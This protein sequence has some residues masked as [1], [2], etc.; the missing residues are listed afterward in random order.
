MDTRVDEI[1]DGIFRCSTLVPDIGPT[2]F[3]FNQFVVRGEHESLLFHTGPRALFASV[4]EAVAT[5]T[6]LDRL[7]WITFGHYEADE[8]GAMND[9]LEAVPNAQVA[10]T[11]IGVLVSINDQAAREPLAMAPDT[12]FDL[13]G[14]RVRGIDTPHVPHGWDAHVLFE[15]TTRTLLCGDLFTHLGDGPALT[16]ND[17][18]DTAAMAEDVFGATALTPTT[19]P[20]IRALADLQPTT[21]AIMHGSSYTG[22]ASGALLALADLYEQRFLAPIA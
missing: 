19:A 12:V 18:L 3:T 1:A 5:V 21:L 13:G 17:L 16:S 15:E 9:F 6:P 11:G 22:D 14:K 7:R 4:H 20:T 2:G 10:H 8:C